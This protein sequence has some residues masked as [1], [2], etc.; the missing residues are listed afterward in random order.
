MTLVK[1]PCK[2]DKSPGVSGWQT[3]KG[4]VNSP[5]VGYMIPE[6]VIVL[7]LDTYKGVKRAD[8]ERAL[9]CELLWH[10]AELQKTRNGGVHYGFRIP[11]GC[12]LR[13]GSDLF[14]VEGLDTRVSG[15]GYIASG[16]G[17]ED[18]T[19]FGI[20]DTLSDPDCLPELPPEAVK[21]LDAGF[22][23]ADDDDFDLEEVLNNQTLGLEFDE[24]RAYVEALPD[25]MAG[26]GGDWVDIGMGIYHETGGSEEGWKLFDEFSRKRGDSYDERKNRV[27]WE[28]WD[29]KGKRAITFATVIKKA[30]GKK[31]IAQDRFEKY[32]AEI[33]GV[34]NINDL[35]GVVNVIGG[36]SLGDVAI[37]LLLKSV[38]AKY[39]ELTGTSP[40]LT[41]LK[42]KLKTSR[43]S[44]DEFGGEVKGAYLNDYVFLTS[45]GEYM[46]KN[47]KATMG[48]RA[49]DVK[50]SRETPPD[51]EGIPQSATQYSNNYIKCVHNGM[52][53]PMFDE[54]FSYEGV[55]YF[56]TYQPSRLE[57]V[58][59]GKTDIV[60]RVKG[61]IAHLLPKQNEQELLINYL[62]HNTQS[63]GKK[64]HWALI[65]QG[66]QGDGKSF[67]AEMMKHVLGAANCRIITVDS[68]DEKFTGWAEGN[69]MVFIEELK[70]DN[71]KKYETLNKLKPYITNPTVPVR[72]M[73]QDVYE[74]INTTNYFALTNFKD[75]LPL[76]DHDRRYCVL[77]S[78][79]QSKES[80]T[81]WMS[82]NPNY[83]PDLYDSMRKNA[84]EILDW[85][86]DYDIPE[87]FLSLSRAPETDAK[88]AMVGMAKG[89]DYMLVDD[90][91][92]EFDCHDI[93]NH[94]VNVTKLVRLISDSMETHYDNFPK[95]TRLKNILLDKGYHMIGIYK[96]TE[97]RK[98]QRIYCKDDSKE[99]KDFRHEDENYIPF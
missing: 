58:G 51:G 39:K 46:N 96:T 92:E 72:R 68:L 95:T 74:A 70:L 26:S 38:Q 7:D 94:V 64:I 16:K 59:V 32:S 54:F 52:Y 76:D 6:G 33:K 89:D 93:N 43:K 29:N 85:L 36:A 78:Q 44:S 5:V 4:A 53:G 86:L 79:W 75:A 35:E 50:Y 61:H 67:L 45:T 27:R 20:D 19:L 63:P 30:G 11:R 91:I 34:D 1:F 71:F 49:F 62:A 8:V 99:A 55:R 28:S 80:L 69:S 10:E 12:Q 60:E 21:V 23:D 3:Y 81:K 47:T 25:S 88:K 57:R 98:N 42:K 18:L 31:V 14:G 17:Y 66:V 48:P 56:N 9:G 65:L 90:A 22:D 84:G 41:T 13:Q 77:F 82:E 40:G 97:G 73:R 87:S 2:D 83:Y 15:K 37:E 24:I